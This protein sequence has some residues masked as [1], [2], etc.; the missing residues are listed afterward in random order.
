MKKSQKWILVL[1]L[2]AVSVSVF[3]LIHPKLNITLSSVQVEPGEMFVV[4][5]SPLPSGS[6]VQIQSSF[7]TEQPRAFPWGTGVVALI[8]VDYRTVPGTYS[9]E[10]KVLRGDRL[11]QKVEQDLTI[12]PRDFQIQKLYVSP[13]L[14]SRRD[15]KLWVEDRL[16]TEQ[17]RSS[18]HPEPLWQGTFLIPL[19]GRITTEFGQIRHINDQESGRHS[20]L[21]IAAAEGTPVVASN[22]G[23]VVLARQLNVTGNTIILD[24]G[25]NLFSSYSHLAKIDVE[26]GEQV[27]RGQVIGAVGNTGFSTG[28]HLHW[29]VSIGGVFVDPH[30]VM[31]ES[32]SKSPLFSIR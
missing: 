28:P 12:E 21:D 17:A 22:Q 19:Q 4:Q 2:I 20:G 23:V 1:A 15:E 16:Y 27:Q 3:L 5:V 11:A 32:L 10:V 6:V 8:P 7:M 24:H 14:L 30:L 29:A 26:L 31:E 9:L 25:L 18:S 13:E